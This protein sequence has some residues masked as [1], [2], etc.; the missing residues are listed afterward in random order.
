[1]RIEERIET[2]LRHK[3]HPGFECAA[4]WNLLLRHLLI[5]GVD[6]NV[7]E[8]G[9]NVNIGVG[10]P[11]GAGGGR[12]GRPGPLARKPHFLKK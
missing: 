3:L 7:R 5:Q 6:L 4:E 9:L 1:L 11:G 10:S 8:W 12:E 2:S